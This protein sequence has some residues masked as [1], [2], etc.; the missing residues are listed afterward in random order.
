M[1]TEVYF[2]LFLQ[3][4]LRTICTVITSEESYPGCGRKI[5]FTSFTRNSFGTPDEEYDEYP[6]MVIISNFDT[7][8]TCAGSLIHPRYILTNAN[9][10]HLGSIN[11]TWVS[12]GPNITF[13]RYGYNETHDGHFTLPS[14]SSKQNY[15]LSKITLHP[16][17]DMDD[18][19]FDQNNP[20]IAV[21]ELEQ[22]VDI[23][24]ICISYNSNANVSL[25]EEKMLH[26]VWQYSWGEYY[27]EDPTTTG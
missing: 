4:F 6:W 21:L 17:Y 13:T 23:I 20:D 24:P 8:K 14:L 22:A 15:F 1:N 9:C 19:G 7:R 25:E 5:D 10:L 11:N 18:K 26:G 12:F 16:D 3:L 27:S 2:I